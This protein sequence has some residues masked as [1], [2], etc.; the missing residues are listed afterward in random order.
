MRR[1]LAVLSA[2]F[3]V[4]AVAFGILY[5]QPHPPQVHAQSALSRDIANVMLN[6]V[7][8]TG[9]GTGY[10][11][12]VSLGDHGDPKSGFSWQ[13]VV[14]GAPSTVNDEI[15]CSSDDSHWQ[16]VST[17]TTATGNFTTVSYAACL[18]I[19]AN[20]TTLTGGT[21]PTVTVYLVFGE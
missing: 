3:L 6:A 8:A 4:F 21:S 18:Y 15:D 13:T 5:F 11:V 20:L 2:A 16:S 1:R 12:P 19:R 9:A 7:T 10:S 17:N 14:T